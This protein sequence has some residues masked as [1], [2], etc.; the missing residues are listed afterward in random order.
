MYEMIYRKAHVSNGS[1]MM[2]ESDSTAYNEGGRAVGNAVLED[3]RTKH[4]K[5]FMKLHEENH[6]DV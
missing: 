3:I 5:A 6:F 1:F 4:P 2:G